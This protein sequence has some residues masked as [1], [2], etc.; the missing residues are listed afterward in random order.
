MRSRN[1]AKRRLRYVHLENF[2]CAGITG[3]D[4]V[5]LAVRR[6]D[7]LLRFCVQAGKCAALPAGSSGADYLLR[8]ERYHPL[9]DRASHKPPWIADA[10]GL[11]AWET[12]RCKGGNK[13]I[14]ERIKIEKNGLLRQAVLLCVGFK[15]FFKKLSEILRPT[16][17]KSYL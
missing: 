1:D 12:A 5:H 14:S 16:P 11:D 3:A 15:K 4:P 10:G 8:K 13:R 9:G 7:L 17:I 6:S 2:V